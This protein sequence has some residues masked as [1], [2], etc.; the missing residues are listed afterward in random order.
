MLML[1]GG[2]KLRGEW[3]MQPFVAAKLGAK[4]GCL[5]APAMG[6]KEEKK[7]AV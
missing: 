5:S 2:P 7:G 1:S 4:G 3:G 6:K